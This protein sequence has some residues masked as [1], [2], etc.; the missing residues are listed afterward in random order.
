LK[1][2][3]EDVYYEVRIATTIAILSLLCNFIT[4]ASF[5]IFLLI[6]LNLIELPSNP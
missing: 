4:M 3:I 6:Y 5:M 1:E 2:R